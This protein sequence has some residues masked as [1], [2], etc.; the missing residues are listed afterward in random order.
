MCVLR[1]LSGIRKDGRSRRTF[2][3]VWEIGWGPDRIFEKYCVC[4]RKL[5]DRRILFS[6]LEMYV[7]VMDENNE[8]V[9][10]A[11]IRKSSFH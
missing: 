11:A 6:C 7:L 1:D 2:A 3:G 4:G 9:W 5:E 8:V 10:P